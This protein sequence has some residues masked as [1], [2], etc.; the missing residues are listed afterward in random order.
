M[1]LLSTPSTACQSPSACIIARSSEY[2]YFLET[3][4]GR[5][6]MQMLK[7]RGD[8]TDPCGMPFLMRP[9]LHR[10]LFPVVRVKLWLLTI[11]GNN[12]VRW[13]YAREILCNRICGSQTKTFGDPGR[14]Q[15]RFAQF[16]PVKGSPSTL[17]M[18]NKKLNASAFV[19]LSLWNHYI[20]HGPCLSPVSLKQRGAVK[21]FESWP[22]TW[23]RRNV[24]TCTS[25]GFIPG[26]AVVVNSL[27]R[28]KLHA[29]IA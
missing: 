13:L 15:E 16:K 9:N 24:H 12:Y 7:R 29:L 5:S 11:S 4:V 19:S 20:S 18:N 17:N 25:E 14:N 21:F 28:K 22:I 2:A 8:R 3:V 6:W 10:L 23:K 27:K 1:S 26:E